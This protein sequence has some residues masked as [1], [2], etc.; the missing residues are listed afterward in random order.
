[1]ADDLKTRLDY[2]GPKDEIGRLVHV[3]NQMMQRLE[4]LFS[5]QQRF[6]ADVSHELRTPLTAIRGHVDLIKRYDMD[7]DSLEAIESEA[8]RMSRMV[9]DL[10]L[11][12]P[13]DY[14][15]LALNL[16]P[17]DLDVIVSE[18]FREAR[19]LAKD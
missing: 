9:G 10:L 19:V 6:V 11:L 13:A 2:H 12:A 16:E 14:G 1:A 5:V 3:F 4:S 18:V 15:G 8:E 7:P 17:L